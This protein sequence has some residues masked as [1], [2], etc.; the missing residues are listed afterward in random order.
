[1]AQRTTQTR[2]SRKAFTVP[3]KSDDQWRNVQEN[4]RQGLKRPAYQTPVTA[5]MINRRKQRS[6]DHRSN[7]HLEGNLEGILS[8]MRNDTPSALRSSF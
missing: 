7:D 5:E 1:M 6:N 8:A 3:N 2:F 4:A